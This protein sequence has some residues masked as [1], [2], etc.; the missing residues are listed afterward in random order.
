MKRI[1]AGLIVLVMA[2]GAFADVGKKLAKAQ[3]KLT[4]QRQTNQKIV[5]VISESNDGLDNIAGILREISKEEE[6]RQRI[7]NTKCVCWFVAGAVI[8]GIAVGCVA[9]SDTSDLFPDFN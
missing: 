4:Q 5:D 7:V 6:R 8:S 2:A 3:E 9:T 1:I